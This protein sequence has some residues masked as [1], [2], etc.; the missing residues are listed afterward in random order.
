[1][2]DFIAAAAGWDIFIV[3]Q[4]PADILKAVYNTVQCFGF[5]WWAY[6]DESWEGFEVDVCVLTSVPRRRRRNGIQWTASSR[7]VNSLDTEPFPNGDLD[8]KIE[9]VE[10]KFL[11]SNRIVRHGGVLA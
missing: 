8:G 7:T 5:D 10:A 2:T 6:I 11:E 1:M 3:I 4:M 9:W